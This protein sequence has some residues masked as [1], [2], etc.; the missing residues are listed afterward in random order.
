MKYLGAYQCTLDAFVESVEAVA[1]EQE[2]DL[3]QAVKSLIE[4]WVKNSDS[5]GYWKARLLDAGTENLL[6]ARLADVQSLQKVFE[7]LFQEPG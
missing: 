1:P 7:S 5:I 2:W 4:F 3:D 6:V